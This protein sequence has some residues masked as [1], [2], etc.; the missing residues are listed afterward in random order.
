MDNKKPKMK[1][2]MWK[3]IG[4]D[5]IRTEIVE[6]KK[7]EALAIQLKSNPKIEFAIINDG[8]E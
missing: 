5:E 8:G 6:A 3:W 1:A 2:V 4:E 7:A